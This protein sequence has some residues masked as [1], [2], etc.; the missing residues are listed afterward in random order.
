MKSKDL[1]KIKLLKVSFH[2]GL[3]SV[4]TLFGFIFLAPNKTFAAS[5]TIIGRIWQQYGAVDL[6][7]SDPAEY[8]GP[9]SAPSTCAG[10]K[11]DTLSFKVNGNPA[12]WSWKCD[13][14][15]SYYEISGLTQGTRVL[16][17]LVRPDPNIPC[18]VIQYTSRYLSATGATLET[19]TGFGCSVWVPTQLSPGLQ[20]PAQHHLW[21][22]IPGVPPTGTFGGCFPSTIAPSTS[23]TIFANFSDSDFNLYNTSIY[24]RDRTLLG[25]W[26]PYGIGNLVRQDTF[27]PTNAI[28]IP[29]SVTAP[30]TPGY[31]QYTFNAKDTFGKGC[32]GNPDVSLFPLVYLGTSY[33]DCNASGQDVCT[34]KVCPTAPTIVTPTCAAMTKE[35][36]RVNWSTPTSWGVPCGV[37]NNSYYLQYRRQGTGTWTTVPGITSTTYLTPPNL[38]SN[39]IYE[40][41]VRGYN[42]EAYGPFGTRTCPTGV[43][44]PGWF[45]S[46]GGDVY[47]GK[48]GISLTQPTTIYSGYS[49]AALAKRAVSVNIPEQIPGYVIAGKNPGQYGQINLVRDTATP[50][51]ERISESSPPQFIKN[52]PY[53]EVWPSRH[54]NSIGNPLFTV[55]T[56][57]INTNT[58]SGLNPNMVYVTRNLTMFGFLISYENRIGFLPVPGVVVVYLTGNPGQSVTIRG[59]ILAQAATHRII[60]VTNRNVI[61]DPAIGTSITSETTRAHIEMAILTSGTITFPSISAG[62]G[63]DTTVIVE[64]PLIAGANIGFSRSR[65]SVDN[66][67]SPSEHIKYNVRYINMLTDQQKNSTVPNYTGLTTNEIIWMN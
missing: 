22:V 30:S 45:T 58:L 34:L 10:V 48:S 16:V 29:V 31:I 35:S 55:P 25:S 9:T 42:G 2:I 64:G 43:A 44:D 53:K 60:L 52:M 23:K 14:L 8:F 3:F 38:I 49:A 59:T 39:S 20:L 13:S 54:T 61:I 47:A 26:P 51:P 7:D 32:T 67:A 12:T 11:N 6:F 66:N 63:T 37:N 4:L 24:R 33:Y 50:A 5:T 65:D 40:F 27:A 21:F 1:R 46:T 15:S 36:I 57:A 41:Q 62:T 28:S 18:S 56:N 17:E 19:T